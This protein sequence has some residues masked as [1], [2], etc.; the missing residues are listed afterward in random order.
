[1]PKNKGFLENEFECEVEIT[2]E[3]VKESWPGKF[4]ILV[5]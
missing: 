1:M 5:E 3:N 2:K 4:G